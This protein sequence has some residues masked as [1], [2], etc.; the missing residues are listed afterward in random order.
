MARMTT[1]LRV[2]LSLWLNAFQSAEDAVSAAPDSPKKNHIPA[3]IADLQK[4]SQ[5]LASVADT[6]IEAAEEEERAGG[7][8]LDY[9]VQTDR[10]PLFVASIRVPTILQRLAGWEDARNFVLNGKNPSHADYSKLEE[11]ERVMVRFLA[12]SRAAAR[13]RGLDRL[14]SP[15][16]PTP[17]C[18][19][20][21]IQAQD[22]AA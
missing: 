18:Q 14:P 13:T 11:A 6:E 20:A 15:T 17:P 16:D 5:T 22:I 2:A 8:N 1:D 7:D 10:G 19:T 4:T 21:T 9:L 3:I 12:D